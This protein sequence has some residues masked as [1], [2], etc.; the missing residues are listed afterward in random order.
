VLPARYDVVVVGAGIMGVASAYYLQKNSPKKKILVVERYGAAGQGN[1]GRSN[2]MFRNTFSSSDNQ[3]LSNASIDYYLHVQNEQEVDLGLQKIGYLWLMDETQLSKSEPYLKRM[4]QNSIEVRRHGREDLKRLL[5]GMVTG[6]DS[7]EQAKLMGLPSVDGGVFG[8]KC[9]RLD[10]DKLVRHYAREFVE[11][12]GEFAFNVDVRGLLL[13]PAKRLGIEDEPRVWQDFRVEEIS[14]SGMPDDKIT[15]KTVVLAGGAWLN[16]LLEPIGIDGHVK[17]KKRQLFSV[18]ASGNRL[19]HLLNAKGFNDHGLLPLVI[20]PKGGV[21]FKPVNEENCFW[22]ASEDEVNRPFID[23]PEHDLDRYPAER[24]YFQ[25][26]I[27][28]VLVSY[29]PDFRESVIKAMWAGLY[30][31][32][33]LDNLPFVFRNENLIVVGGDSGSGIMKGDS[34]G[35]IADAVYRDQEEAA[36]YGGTPYRTS[37]LGF[38]KRDV[39]REEWTL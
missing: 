12:G 29:F 4:E 1:T 13:G 34:I 23:L 2:A 37:K 8:P 26:E 16:E 9:G 31:Y 22:I 20:L 21:H 32:N 19:Q 39:E 17:S 30:A 3:K 35:R 6:F 24:K 11:A 5:P 27:Y 33:T 38:E 36:L 15:A 25:N 18:P 14:A 7:D 10:P 28:P